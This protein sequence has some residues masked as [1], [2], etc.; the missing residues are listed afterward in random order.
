MVVGGGGRDGG[1][2]EAGGV[3]DGGGG[4]E[5]LPTAITVSFPPLFYLLR[6]AERG[7]AP[8]PPGLLGNDVPA[9]LRVQGGVGGVELG[10]DDPQPPAVLLGPP[11]L[12]TTCGVAWGTK[13]RVPSMLIGPKHRFA[14]KCDRAEHHMIRFEWAPP[15]EKKKKKERSTPW[16]DGLWMARSVCEAIWRRREWSTKRTKRAAAQELQHKSCTTRAAPQEG[17]AMQR[18][19]PWDTDHTRGACH[20]ARSTMGYGPHKRSMPC[21]ACGESVW[22]SD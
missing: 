2:R 20:A 21:S 6:G 10:L 13:H 8:E 22:P 1:G 4:V 14:A 11:T 16:L 17:R 19:A 15:R 9:E 3:R 18:G 7:V 5:G 12:T